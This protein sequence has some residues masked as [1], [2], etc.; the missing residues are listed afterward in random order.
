MPPDVA[1][2][3]T[4][5]P[6]PT[7]NAQSSPVHWPFLTRDVAA[8]PAA[9][10]RRYED[11]EVDELPLYEP[12]GEGE[13]VYVHFEKAGLATMRAVN[14]L[15]RALGLPRHAIGV[16]GLKDAR[17]VARQTVSIERVDPDRVRALDIPRIRILSV[18]R[19]R[20][21]LRIGHLRGNRFRIKLRETDVDRV[22]D[23]RRVMD[24]LAQRGVPNYFGSQRFG[25]RGDTWQIGQ[26]LL[27][28]DFETAVELIAGRPGPSDTGAVLRAR[29]LFGQGRY[30]DAARAWP[31]GF[32]EP[33]RVCRVMAKTHGNARRAI[34]SLERRMLEFYVSAW[35]SWL[36]NEVLSERV[37]ELDRVANGD[38]AFKHD[39]GAVF[40][41]ES[42]EI[43]QPRADRFEISATG[44][45]FGHRMT[46]P[47]GN[48]DHIEQGVIQRHGRATDD[49]PRTGLFRCNGGRRALRFRPEEPLVDVGGDDA[50][51]FI[52]LQ[53][54]LP[55][56][57]YATSVLREICKDRMEEGLL[58]EE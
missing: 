50:G 37:D 42:A 27:D 57:C 10:K 38:L 14:D 35:Q 5:P 39:N 24:T 21:K 18:T 43:E 1:H 3:E 54:T 16:A 17:A 36:F 32:R 19:H 6:T 47:G 29:Q 51:P 11:F 15:A 22:V 12:C 40:R 34:L 58:E 7:P 28:D 20:N 56:G 45:L 26:A 23:V 31:Y 48:A 4:P 9:I 46:R 49:L 8:L 53:F 55:A 25:G 2:P 30:D 44:P 13:H 41:V 33:Q 52:E